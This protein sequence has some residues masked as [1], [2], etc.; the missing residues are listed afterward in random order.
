M[1]IKIAILLLCIPLI[2]HAQ[3]YEFQILELESQQPISGV[4]V[5][6]KKAQV[7][8]ISDEQGRVWIDLSDPIQLFFTH[9]SFE[10]LKIKLNNNSERKIFLEKKA[11][12]L[13]DVYVS[14]N[15]HKR[16]F[17]QPLFVRDY[18]FSPDGL[19]VLA[20]HK[21]P[22]KSSVYLLDDLG[23][24]IIGRPLKGKIDRLQKDCNDNL[25]VVSG[26][27]YFPLEIS[28]TNTALYPPVKS[29]EDIYFI[30]NCVLEKNNAYYWKYY[31][32]D[33]LILV[34]NKANSINQENIEMFS[35][36]DPELLAM[37]ADEVNFML[38]KFGDENLDTWEA[39]VERRFADEI[40]YPTTYAPLFEYGKKKIIFDH[41][42][43]D[44]TY[45]YYFNEFDQMIKEEVSDIHEIPDWEKV[46]LRDEHNGSFYTLS[47]K[48]GYYKVY[49][50]DVAKG[51]ERL[52][53]RIEI[54]FIKNINIHNGEAY[55]IGKSSIGTGENL[56]LYR[57][58]L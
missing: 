13:P 28:T 20:Y 31:V 16:L 54:P 29:K 49:E 9:V 18:E 37:N 11:I 22:N 48:N 12:Q 46:I 2:L 10:T 35:L 27:L 52:I 30:D 39:E 44:I 33:S 7:S 6:D 15:K 38:M 41:S 4:H 24:P 3:K 23:E 36:G 5:A 42:S 45:L 26:E 43:Q 14:S 34:Y 32:K 51:E 57:Q 8:G 19:V 50:I 58:S 40:M 21:N 1:K 53:D 55:F 56:K 25:Y 17:K 47:E